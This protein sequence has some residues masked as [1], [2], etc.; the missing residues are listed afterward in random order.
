MTRFFAFKC[1]S[2]FARTFGVVALFAWLGGAGVAAL[3][4]GQVVRD[5]SCSGIGETALLS[6]NIPT[7]P[8]A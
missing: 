6:E 4:D 5:W 1:R 8:G 3:G 7:Q 2:R